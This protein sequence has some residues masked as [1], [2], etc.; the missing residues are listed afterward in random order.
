MTADAPTIDADK[1]VPNAARPAT[2]PLFKNQR[3]K[4]KT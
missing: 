1:A 3:E 2:I 4:G